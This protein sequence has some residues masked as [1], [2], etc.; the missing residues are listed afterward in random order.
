MIDDFKSESWGQVFYGDEIPYIYKHALTAQ[1]GVE[2][3]AID[4]N[5]S[6][7][8]NGDMRTQPGQGEIPTIERIPA[9]YVLDASVRY[10]LLK[11][12]TLKINAVNLLGN[13]YL[14]SRHPSGLRAGHPRG[15]YFGINYT[16]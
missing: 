9:H 6:L 4:C 2:Y 14:V 3:K 10:R 16:L 1:L 13:R 12:L 15:V 11:G 5:L 8:Y 7:R